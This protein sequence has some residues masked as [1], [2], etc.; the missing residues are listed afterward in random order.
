MVQSFQAQGSA[1]FLIGSVY[2]LVTFH[3]N[4]TSPCKVIW[5]MLF[6]LNTIVVDVLVCNDVNNPLRTGTDA[7]LLVAL[8]DVQQTSQFR[9]RPL[10]I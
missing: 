9:T 1:P 3:F 10:S 4:L 6:C 8:W 2:I 5:L 7:A